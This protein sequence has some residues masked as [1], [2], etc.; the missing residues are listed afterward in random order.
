M[1]MAKE[2]RDLSSKLSGGD[3]QMAV[4]HTHK[5]TI[6]TLYIYIY[7]ND[8]ILRDNQAWENVDGCI[9]SLTFGDSIDRGDP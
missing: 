1:K 8:L 4:V 2:E 9:G 6:Q 3:V 5:H 7:M